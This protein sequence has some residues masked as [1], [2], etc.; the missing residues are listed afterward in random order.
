MVMPDFSTT[1]S[2]LPC[3]LDRLTSTEGNERGVSVRAYREAVIRDVGWLLNASKSFSRGELDDYPNV[4]SSVLN[5]GLPSTPGQQAGGVALRRVIESGVL[6]A[7]R[8]FE[9]RLMPK[10]LKVRVDDDVSARHEGK[11]AFQIEGQLWCQ[12]FPEDMLIQTEFDLQSEDCTVED[13]RNG[14]PA[15]RAI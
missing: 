8:T 14:R 4:R 2:V 11:V 12:P 6:E 13:V 10:T 7:L 3:L 1:E 5:F 15:S 9:P